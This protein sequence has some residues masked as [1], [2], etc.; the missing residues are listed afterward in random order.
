[1]TNLTHHGYNAGHPW[2][3]VLGG[4]I[5]S[6]K[7]IRAAVQESAYQGYLAGEIFEKNGLA[8][9]RRS[10]MLQSLRGKVMAELSGDIERYRQAA[11]ELRRFRA[12]NTCNPKPVCADVHTAISL[13]FSHIYN[14]LANL[15]TLD[16]LPK[17]GELFDL[18]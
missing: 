15:R 4:K 2:F 14:G 13:K 8:E 3:Y 7:A 11:C 12:T 6:I 9:P 16:S 5:P 17:Q 18:F 1:M 10:K